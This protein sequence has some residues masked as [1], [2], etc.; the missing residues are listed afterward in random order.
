MSDSQEEL[1]RLRKRVQELE[2]ILEAQNNGESND[3]T[4]RQKIQ[5]MSSE[6]VDTNPYRCSTMPPTL[7]LRPITNLCSVG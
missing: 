2:Q 7:L 4:R 1:Q 5:E 3:K 6:V